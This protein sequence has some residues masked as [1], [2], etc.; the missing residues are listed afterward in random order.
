MVLIS[1]QA[2]KWMVTPKISRRSTEHVN[3]RLK[4]FF[5]FG[6]V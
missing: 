3:R 6:D 5:Y 1:G 4:Q 2:A